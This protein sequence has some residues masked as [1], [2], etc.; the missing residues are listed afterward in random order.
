[1][2]SVLKVLKQEG[3]ELKDNRHIDMGI[4]IV[5]QPTLKYV[6]IIKKNWR[7]SLSTTGAILSVTQSQQYIRELTKMNYLVKTINDALD[8]GL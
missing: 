3:L 2:E 6:S 8:N 1:M 7:F 4:N 5:S